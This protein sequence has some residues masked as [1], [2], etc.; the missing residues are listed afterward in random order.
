[1]PG[2]HGLALTFFGWVFGERRLSLSPLKRSS[3]VPM[4]EPVMF[5]ACPSNRSR[6]LGAPTDGA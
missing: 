5:G 2:L 3:L 4:D 1:M 6:P